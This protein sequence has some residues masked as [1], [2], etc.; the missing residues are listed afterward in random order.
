VLTTADAHSGSALTI[1]HPDAGAIFQLSKAL[2]QAVQRIPIEVRVDVSTVVR[3]DVV[4]ANNDVLA[5]FD[6]PPY[7]LLWPLQAGQHTLIARAYLRDGRVLHSAPVQFTV[8]P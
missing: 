2:P 1:T 6:R 8:L 7:R 5:R 4:T 3:V